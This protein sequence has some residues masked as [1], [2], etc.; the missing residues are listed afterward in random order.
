[1]K[2]TTQAEQPIPQHEEPC[3]GCPFARTT[4]PGA[5]G[6]N[7]PVTYVEQAALSF[8][9]PC[10]KHV[11][12]DDPGWKQDKSKP[13]CAGAAIYR[14]NRAKRMPRTIL[15]L[16][17]NKEKV[18]ATPKE[19][20]CHHMKIPGII[21]D[22]ANFGGLEIVSEA[23]LFEKELGKAQVMPCPASL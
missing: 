15:S 6:G 20:I 19:F 1:M 16:P 2:A 4:A 14:A 12:F 7:I 17:P 5:L 8:W 21:Y 10:H 13:Q 18:F 3:G 11:E 22:I 9:L 23:I